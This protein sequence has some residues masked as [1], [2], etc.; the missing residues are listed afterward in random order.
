VILKMNALVE[1][2]SIEAL[3]RASQAG[4]RIELIVRGM[5]AL[6]P[7]VPGVSATITVRSI[8]GRFLEH[9]RVWYFANGG[10]PELYCSSADFMERNFFRRVEVAFPISEPDQRARI[11]RNLEASLADNTQAWQLGPDGR[12]VRLA[13]GDAEPRSSQLELLAR[14]AAGADAAS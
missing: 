5:C 10:E 11:L 1:R 7:G 6:R 3:Y 12:Y 2:E 13:P 4:V 8:V 14:Y 9:S